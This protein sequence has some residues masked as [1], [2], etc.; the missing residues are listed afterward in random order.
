MIRKLGNGSFK[1]Q[2]EYQWSHDSLTT[3]AFSLIEFETEMII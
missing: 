2:Q 3:S 1:S